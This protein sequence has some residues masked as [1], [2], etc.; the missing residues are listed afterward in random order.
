MTHTISLQ[1]HLAGDELSLKVWGGRECLRL[2][3]LMDYSKPFRN[4][5]AS[6][7]VLGTAAVRWS[8]LSDDLGNGLRASNPDALRIAKMSLVALL[9]AKTLAL[10]LQNRTDLFNMVQRAVDETLLSDD[11]APIEFPEWRIV[12]RENVWPWKLASWTDLEAGRAA[13][14]VRLLHFITKNMMKTYSATLLTGPSAL[15]APQGWWLRLKIPDAE[16]IR[17]L[18]PSATLIAISSL[19]SEPVG[20]SPSILSA[21]LRR[22]NK[23]YESP[24]RVPF[25]SDAMALRAAI[26]SIRSPENGDVGDYRRQDDEVRLQDDRKRQQ[27]HMPPNRFPASFLTSERGGT[28]GLGTRVGPEAQFTWSCPGCGRRVPKD[29]TTCRC[30]H[31]RDSVVSADGHSREGATIQTQESGASPDFLRSQFRGRSLAWWVGC[32]VGL[33]VAY[34]IETKDRLVMLGM[35]LLG[36]FVGDAAWSYALRVYRNGTIF[37]RLMLAVA[38][39]LFAVNILPTYYQNPFVGRGGYEWS[40]GS[41]LALGLAVVLVVLAVLT[42]PKDEPF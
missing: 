42:K 19:D 12:G 17:V 26:E 7:R 22:V 35:L 14:D 32:I 6:A 16:L 38:V 39:F 15:F 4:R 5:D 40:D 23:Y 36:G 31:S 28:V 29:V 10:D 37:R 18:L 1:Q 21:L 2:E 8:V 27:G 24:E 41:R 34:L 25:G 11:W 20:D 13:A 30:G 33:V 3:S 9:Y